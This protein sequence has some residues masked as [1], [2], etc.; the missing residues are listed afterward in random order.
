M[1][2]MPQTRTVRLPRNRREDAAVAD[3]SAAGSVSMPDVLITSQSE[4]NQ[5]VVAE[6]QAA[7]DYVVSV[8]PEFTIGDETARAVLDGHHSLEAALVDGVDPV[9]VEA[10]TVEHAD[11]VAA[12]TVDP[13]LDAVS[14]T[15]VAA[16]AADATGDAA[17]TE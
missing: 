14:G 12:G 7:G 10:G 8:T 3:A 17:A 15:E 1:F 2:A 5:D 16:P 9:L 11:E 4:I 13:V 6:K